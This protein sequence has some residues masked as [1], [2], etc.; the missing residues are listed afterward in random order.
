VNLVEV[1]VPLSLK[2]GRILIADGLVKA[3]PGPTLIPIH[4]LLMELER[5]ERVEHDRDQSEP[6]DEE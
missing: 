6:G 3:Q 1:G 4:E 2:T 5:E